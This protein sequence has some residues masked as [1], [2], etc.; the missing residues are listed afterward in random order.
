MG[1][2][3]LDSQTGARLANALGIFRMC[4]EHGTLSAEIEALHRKIGELASGA[5][6]GTKELTLYGGI[7]QPSDSQEAQRAN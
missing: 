6:S 5:S 4:L 3:T 1:N 2:G 7:Y